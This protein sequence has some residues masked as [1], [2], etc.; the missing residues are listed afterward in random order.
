MLGGGAAWMAHHHHVFL[1]AGRQL[2][3]SMPRHDGMSQR[4]P[5]SSLPSATLHLAHVPETNPLAESLPELLSLS[6]PLPSSVD[7]VDVSSS[8]PLAS[9]AVAAARF[10]AR[11]GV[12]AVR[13]R[14]AAR[15]CEARGA[16]K[17]AATLVAPT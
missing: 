12:A 6:S 15:E 8:L 7:V 17:L 13:G 1:S 16:V 14:A 11:A 3:Q 2:L 5:S 9:I 10:A 4:R